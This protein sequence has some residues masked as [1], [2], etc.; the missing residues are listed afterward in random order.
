MLKYDMKLKFKG[1]RDYVHGTD[2]FNETLEWLC[3]HRDEIKDIDFSL[4][5]LACKQLTVVL[6]AVSDGTEPIAVCAYTSGG[7]REKAR[8]VETDQPVVGRYSYPEDEIVDSM[9]IDFATRK[10]ILRTETSFSDIEV[11][12]A[13]TKALHL[14]VFPQLEGKWL[15]VRARFSAY[16]RHSIASE[17][18]LVISSSLNDKLTR[19]E[20]FLNNVK[21]GEI[22]FSIV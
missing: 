10:G 20:A 2:I 22:Y 19:S 12:V 15:F 9:E 21:V 7:K 4:H 6:G 5:R 14:K 17:R 18:A 1:Q 16:A 8:L 11:W 3:K 13:M